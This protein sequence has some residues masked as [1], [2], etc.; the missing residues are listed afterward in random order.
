MHLVVY[1]AAVN[2]PVVA[3]GSIGI[4]NKSGSP[5]VVLLVGRKVWISDVVMRI[6]GPPECLVVPFWWGLMS[7][8]RSPSSC[9]PFSFSTPLVRVVF[10]CAYFPLA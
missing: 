2:D 9:S 5:Q 3:R 6:S 8:I 1:L 10:A 4:D 7:L